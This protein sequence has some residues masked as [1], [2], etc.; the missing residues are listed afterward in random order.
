MA[1]K[2]IEE[3]TSV[4]GLKIECPRCGDELS[5]KRARLFSMYGTYP[6]AAQKIIRQRIES[7][8]ELGDELQYRAVRLEEDRETKPERIAIGA[9]A[10]NFGQIS[11][12]ILPAFL[13]FPYKQEE[14]RILFKPVDYVVFEGLSRRRSIEAIRFVELKTGGGYLSK[15]QKQIR[16]RVTEGKIKHRIIGQ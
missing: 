8:S 7:A 16:D 2:I 3:L 15:K 5:V 11:E 1:R 6:P 9:Q 4:P 12:Q 14:C 10:T 13:T